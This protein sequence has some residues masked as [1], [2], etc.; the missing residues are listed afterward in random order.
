MACRMEESLRHLSGRSRDALRRQGHSP[1]VLAG[2]GFGSGVERRG[3]LESD[4]L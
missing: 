3:S 4:C 2:N 1:G